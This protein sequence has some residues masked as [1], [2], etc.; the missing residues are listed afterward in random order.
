MVKDH[1]RSCQGVG[2]VKGNREVRVDIP[3]GVASGTTLKINGEGGEGAKGVRPGNLLLQIRVQP[4]KVFKRDGADI[5]V[6]VSIP[7]TQAILGGSVQVPTLTGDVLLKIRP[8]TQPGQKQVLR[9]KGVRVLNSRHYGDQY[10]Q[11]NVVIPMNITHRQRQII[12]EF[13]REESGET[14][15]VAAEGSG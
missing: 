2:V 14:E 3:A 10:V 1:C 6:D 13:A 7:F 9:G 5:S 4:D 12:E 15:S 11:I 8:G